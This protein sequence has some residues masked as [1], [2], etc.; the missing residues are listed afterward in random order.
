MQAQ[1]LV[2]FPEPGIHQPHQLQAPGFTRNI[3]KPGV[4]PLHL[5]Q[6]PQDILV[7]TDIRRHVL[8]PPDEQVAPLA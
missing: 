3:V 2:H 7:C 4:Q 5:R 8:G 6:C 1:H